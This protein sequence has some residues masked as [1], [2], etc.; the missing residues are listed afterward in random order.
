MT[1]WLSRVEE[2]M[3]LTMAQLS[4]SEDIE[5]EKNNYQV[6]GVFDQRVECGRKKF[7]RNAIVR[8]EY[9][10]RGGGEEKRY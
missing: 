1:E 7:V 5:R 4:S 8:L 2:K 3:Q 9:L 6:G 10:P